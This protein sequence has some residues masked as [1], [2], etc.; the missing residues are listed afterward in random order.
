MPD[1]YFTPPHRGTFV[2]ESDPQFPESMGQP[3]R[4]MAPHTPQP[5]NLYLG[6]DGLLHEEQ[7]PGTYGVNGKS[8]LGGHIYGPLD[9]ADI[10]LITN[11]GYGAYLTT[12]PKPV[13]QP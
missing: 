10:D 11:S 6:L 3:W 1:T 13:P 9:Q 12:D 4:S 7:P 2:P 5:P 8:F